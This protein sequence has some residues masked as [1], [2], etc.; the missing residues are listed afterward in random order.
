MII[1][2]ISSYMSIASMIRSGDKKEEHIVQELN[3]ILANSSF[4]V[5]M[6]AKPTLADYDVFFALSEGNCLSAE[7]VTEGMI[8]LRRW[9][10]AVQASV[11][12]LLACV[13]GVSGS[14]AKGVPAVTL[15]SLEYGIA[16]PVP[17][18][19]FGD[20]ED[21]PVRVESTS[22]SSAGAASSP[23]PPAAAAAAQG[24]KKELT[25]EEKKAAADKRAKKAAEKAKNK[26]AQPT[27]NDAAAAV[28]LDVTA[29]DIRVGKII[30]VW[31]HEA[32]DKLWCEK[33]DLG[34]GEPRQVLSGLRAFYKK[35]EMQGRNVLVL[36]NLKARNL[37]GVSSHGMVLCASNADHSAVEFVIPPEGAK[38]GE[39]VMFEG[40]T[41]EPEP[42]NKV[43]KK[44]ILE[45]LAP[46]L[47]TNNDGVVVWK[48]I[49]SGTSAG[50][51][52][53]SKGMKDAQV[54]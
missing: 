23:P 14:V 20:E 31:E 10:V 22:T 8:H 15:A 18:F 12:E 9:V 27:Q 35:E 40:L 46:D 1:A 34:E 41:G 25:E 17:V 42:E 24:G 11:E 13:S 3:E 49:K 4:L 39:R 26:P 36:C 54:S 16:D 53:A 52:V 30:E 33:I 51:C 47:K 6:T 48:G 43:A 44:K 50:P 19:F 32:S 5:G 45:K 38:I 28:E 2:S 7:I 21:M 37:A 29:L